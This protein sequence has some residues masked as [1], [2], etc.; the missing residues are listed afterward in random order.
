MKSAWSHLTFGTF[1]M[2]RLQQVSKG[3]SPLEL[4]YSTLAHM[5]HPKLSCVGLLVGKKNDVMVEW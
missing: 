1:K 4:I 3:Q 5:L 2:V